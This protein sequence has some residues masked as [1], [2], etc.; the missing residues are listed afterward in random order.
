[1]NIERYFRTQAYNNALANHRLL[2][3]CGRLSADDLAAKRV[4]FFPS[5]MRTL[6]HNLTVDW[7]Y[8]SAL[9]GASIGYAAFDPITPCPDFADLLREQRSVDARL[10]AVCDA[11]GL[12]L[13]RAI[14]I[15]RDKRTQVEP[16]DRVLLHL[17]QHQIHH[18]GQTHAMLS[19]TGVPPPQLDE[20]F[21][22]DEKEQSLRAADFAELG[23]SEDHIWR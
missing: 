10:I 7:F 6:N 21:L 22:G 4:S 19:G 11:P 9:E 13:S 5:I 1:M 23:F 15:K 18:R 14:H 16:A 2:H 3:A 8:V 17:F 20:F 12:D